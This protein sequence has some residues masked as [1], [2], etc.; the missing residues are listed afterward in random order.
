MTCS[1]CGVATGGGQRF[2][3]GCGSPVSVL[4][5]APTY[6]VAP[7][8]APGLVDRAVPVSLPPL[9]PLTVRPP[10]RLWNGRDRLALLVGCWVVALVLLA[11]AAR[12]LL[13]PAE[14]GADSPQAA[15]AQLA[16]GIADLDVAAVVRVVD[17]EE[18]ADPEVVVDA[19][20]RLEDRLLRVGDQPPGD[21]SE[22]LAAADG[23]PSVGNLGRSH[24]AVLSALE[25]DL[26]DLDLAVEEESGDGVP[27]LILDGVLEVRSDPRG[28]GDHLR[29]R[30]SGAGL[31]SYDMPLAGDWRYDGTPVPAY[32]VT[33]ER[34]GRW[35]V[36]LRATEQLYARGLDGDG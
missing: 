34:E 7:A 8:P 31:A 23:S 6:P 4:A 30:V 14:T 16:Q 24:L 5:P 35:Y 29:G 20:D 9:T 12:P 2:C 11:V 36:S 22:V 25:L 3:G 19:Y 28:L 33:V 21:L 18:A 32:L 10:L 26:D 1:T 17:P 15:V 13:F 27:V